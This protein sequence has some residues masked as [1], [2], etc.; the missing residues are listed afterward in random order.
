MNLCLCNDT[1][2]VI[3]VW[4]SVTL[5]PYIIVTEVLLRKWNII[6]TQNGFHISKETV[7]SITYSE[8]LLGA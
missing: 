6:I 8:T 1:T 5:N 7:L 2:P 3:T 4:S